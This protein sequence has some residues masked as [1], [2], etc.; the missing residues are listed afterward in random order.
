[1]HAANDHTITKTRFRRKGCLR[2]RRCIRDRS[3]DRRRVCT[4]Q[5]AIGAPLARVCSKPPTDV[6]AQD[7]LASRG[8]LVSIIDRELSGANDAAEEISRLYGVKAIGLACDVSDYDQVDS[9]VH[10][11]VKRLGRLDCAVNAAAIPG[12]HR[13]TGEYPIE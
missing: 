4:V 10:E 12:A 3:G 5:G 8:A 11:T 1:M 9:A 13:V 2:C 6:P 7:V